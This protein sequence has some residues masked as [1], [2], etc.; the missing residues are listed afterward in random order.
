MEAGTVNGAVLFYFIQ[1]L[2][3]GGEVRYLVRFV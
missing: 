3:E 1:M 2:N